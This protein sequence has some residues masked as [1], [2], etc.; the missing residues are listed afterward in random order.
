MAIYATAICNTREQ[1]ILVGMLSA[2]LSTEIDSAKMHRALIQVIYSSN[3]NLDRKMTTTLE[4]KQVVQ[5]SRSLT[6]QK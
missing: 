2:A 1:I 3:H 4:L 5:C 6:I